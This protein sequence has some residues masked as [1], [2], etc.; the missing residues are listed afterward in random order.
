MPKGNEKLMRNR[1]HSKIMEDIIETGKG[2]PQKHKKKME[3]KTRQK[4]EPE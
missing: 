4:K 3:K 2:N 1:E